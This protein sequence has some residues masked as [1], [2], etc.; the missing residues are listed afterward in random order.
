MRRVAVLFALL[1]CNPAIVVQALQPPAGANPVPVLSVDNIGLG[2]VPIRGEWQF[3]LGD[4]PH[5]AASEYDDS[6]W[7]HITANNT[8][9][10]QTHPSYTGF[11][12]YRR[13]LDIH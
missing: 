10:A 3:H 5:W 6:N 12:W 2:V 7:E 4:D 11:A 1:L 8:W 9:G 13:H